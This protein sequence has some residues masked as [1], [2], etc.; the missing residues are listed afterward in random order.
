MET[1]REGKKKEES[2][3]KKDIS[4]IS[5]CL[6]TSSR[7]RKDSSR[8]DSMALGKT[9]RNRNKTLLGKKKAGLLSQHLSPIMICNRWEGGYVRLADHGRTQGRSKYCSSYF[10]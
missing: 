3:E 5:L 9:N 10:N 4:F 8:G 7:A 6:E 2:K 1:S